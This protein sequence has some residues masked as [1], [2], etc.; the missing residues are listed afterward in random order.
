[1]S[2]AVCALSG[3]GAVVPSKE[4]KDELFCSESHLVIYQLDEIRALILGTLDDATR[5]ELGIRHLGLENVSRP[6]KA[7]SGTVW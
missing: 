6:E 1:M 4:G 5:R 3:C 7:R 2:G